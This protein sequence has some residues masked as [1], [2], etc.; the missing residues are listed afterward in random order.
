[1]T[2]PKTPKEAAD[3]IQTARDAII[4]AVL[5]CDFS[6]VFAT[7]FIV[8]ESTLGLSSIVGAKQQLI[9]ACGQGRGMGRDRLRRRAIQQLEQHEVDRALNTLLAAVKK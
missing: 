6:E 7:K 1:M 8:G 5:L 4:E 3:D 2:T 9:R